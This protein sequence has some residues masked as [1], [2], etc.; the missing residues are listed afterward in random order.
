MARIAIIDDEAPIGKLI[1]KMAKMEGHDTISALNF[2]QGLSILESGR[3]DIVFLDINLPDGNGLEMIPLIKAIPDSPEIIVITGF[4]NP[5]SA[6]TAVRMGAW[7]YLLKPLSNQQLTLTIKS[8][9][10]YRE[11]RIKDSMAANILKLEGVKTRSPLLRECLKA[12]AQAAQGD[13]NVFITGE[14]GTGKDFY[15]QVLHNSSSRASNN[16]VVADCAAL[17]G[18]LIESLLF[19]S[20]KG[21]FTDSKESKI[22]L[23]EQADKGTLFLDEVGDLPLVN[24]KAFLKVLDTQRF[25]PIGGNHEIQSDFRLISATNRHLHNLVQ[26]GLFRKDLYYRLR[27]FTIVLPPLRECLEDLEPLTLYYMY[28]RCKR[29]N[30]EPIKFS[31]DFFDYCSRYSWPG[32]IRELFNTIETMILQSPDQTIFFPR[33]LPDDIRVKVARTSVKVEPKSH[34]DNKTDETISTDTFLS[35]KDF[36]TATLEDAQ[37]NYFLSLMDHTKGDIKKACRISGLSR[38]G[39]YN[40]L[41]KYNITRSIWTSC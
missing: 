8:A 24:Q 2:K 30:L 9:L 39:I 32:N 25:R 28:K 12:L 4:G 6:E 19:G 11:S 34:E 5:E 40:F 14:T 29:M 33:H 31:A 41:K 38:S 36:K 18:S 1:S 37:K 13:V 15:A 3:F 16:F 20:E 23:V 21:A 7:D 26:K 35:F 10:Q 27:A 22:G 17:P